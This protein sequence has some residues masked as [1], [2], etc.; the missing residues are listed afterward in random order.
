MTPRQ[1]VGRLYVDRH[2]IRNMFSV[3][4]SRP[5][6]AFHYLTVPDPGPEGKVHSHEYALDV[7]IEATALNEH[8]YVVD[9]DQLDELVNE[10]IG[11][12][13]GATLNDLD[14][15]AGVNP[16]LE[17]LTTVIADRLCESSLLQDE[18]FSQL[19][20]VM[21]EDTSARAEYTRELPV[22]ST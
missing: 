14:G 9:I 20:I 11:E 1:E 10:V 4:V 21:T 13:E 15:F 22:P 6:T 19:R 2:T 7:C 16:S 8:R 18:R 5:F 3:A 17:H 12:F